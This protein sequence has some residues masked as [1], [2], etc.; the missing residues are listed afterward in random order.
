[1]IKRTVTFEKPDGRK[2]A[3]S[4]FRI[5][6]LEEVEDFVLLSYE[7]DDAVKSISVVG[8]FDEILAEIEPQKTKKDPWSEP[9]KD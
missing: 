8:G 5:V 7:F 6:A 2:L 4:L 3:V 1:M 9:W